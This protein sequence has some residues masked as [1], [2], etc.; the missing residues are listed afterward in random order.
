MVKL[1]S[2]SWMFFIF[3][4][5]CGLGLVYIRLKTKETM[6]VPQSDIDKLFGMEGDQKDKLITTE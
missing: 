5:F 1:L 3:A 6:G 4:I 2:I